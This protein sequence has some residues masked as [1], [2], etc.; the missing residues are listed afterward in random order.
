MSLFYENAKES[1]F[2][3]VRKQIE[4]AS[5]QKLEDIFQGKIVILRSLLIFE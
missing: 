1:T 3:N 5:G 4:E 2:E